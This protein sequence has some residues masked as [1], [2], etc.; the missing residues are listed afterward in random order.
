M[1]GIEALHLFSICITQINT[2]MNGQV[3]GLDY[4]A[5]ISAAKALGYDEEMMTILFKP[6]EQAVIEASSKNADSE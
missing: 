1:Q 6:I 4:Q 2:S 5:W 3:L